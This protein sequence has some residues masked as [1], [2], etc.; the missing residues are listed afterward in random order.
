MNEVVVYVEWSD[1]G[2]V[3]DRWDS[4]ENVLSEAARV[5]STPMVSAGILLGAS[6]D[7]IVLGL[8][9]NPHRGDVNLSMV[10][11][12]SAIRRFDTWSPP[13]GAS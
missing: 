5:V 9:V 7:H 12:R 13:D 3:A 10:I 11:P 6:D 2:I 1:S 8:S 4:R